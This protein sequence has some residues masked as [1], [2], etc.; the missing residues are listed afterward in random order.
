MSQVRFYVSKLSS[1]GASPSNATG[2][3]IKRIFD[4]TGALFLILL[5]SPLMALI[6]GLIVLTEGRPFFIRH[7]RIG[8]GGSEFHCLKFRTMVANADD[9]LGEYLA[10]NP[11]AEQQWKTNRKLT[12][13]PRI[14]ELGRV[15]RKSSLDELLQ[16]FNILRGDMSLVGPRPIV[17]DESTN[18][19]AAFQEYIRAR[20]GLTGL[21]QVKGRSNT[22]Y[23]ERVKLDS[24]YV[25]SWSFRGDVVILLLTVPSVL[26]AKGSV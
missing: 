5:L 14:T 3:Y 25:S 8:H 21:W 17:R 22:S 6:A 2:G 20:P 23:A 24:E 1:A 7:K 11:S 9:I 12:D 19:G 26:A 13:D 4:V 15:L 16:L 10:Q 18:Y